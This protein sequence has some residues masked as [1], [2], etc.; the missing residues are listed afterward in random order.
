MDQSGLDPESHTEALDG[1]GRLHRIGRSARGIW[2]PIR[3]LARSSAPSS[4]RILDVATGGGDLPIALWQLGLRAGVSLEID[5]FDR[6]SQAVA[7]ARQKACRARSGVRFF[8]RDALAQEI[9]PGYDVVLCSLFLHHLERP[10]ALSLL[11]RMAG[12]AGR[13]VLLHD[14][15]RSRV[16]VVLMGA[17]AALFTQSPVVHA[18]APQSVQAAFTIPEVSAM[19]QEAGLTGARIV[20]KHPFRFLLIWKRPAADG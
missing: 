14:L 17:G 19:A 6:S 5:G 4:L 11:K 8:L 16:N 9:P 1:L 10:E 18:D 3:D 20:P 2:P 13:M 7:Y 15:V 12:A